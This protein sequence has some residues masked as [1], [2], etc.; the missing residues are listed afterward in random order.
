MVH[1]VKIPVVHVITLLELG[2]A[3]QNTLHTVAHLDR[4]RF[5]PYLLCG[6]GGILDPEARQLN[7]VPVFFIPDLVREIRPHRDL[8]A[9][10]QLRRR[11]RHIRRR[12][13]HHPAIVH[14]HSSKAGILGRWAAR[15]EGVPRVV[16]TFHGFG[17]HPQ[18][19]PWV[20][21]AFQTAE[22]LTG[23]ITD[24]FIVVS[25]QNMKTA[26][27]LGIAG[28]SRM[29]L[30]RSGIAIEAFQDAPEGRWTA[31]RSLGLEADDP[32][33]LMVA[34]L[35][36]Q[37]APVD[38]VAVAHRVSE[39]WPQCRFLLAGDGILRP[40]VEEA[41][42]ALGLKDRFRLLGW[43]RDIPQLLHASDLLVLT[44]RWEGLPRVL[45][46]AM[47]AGLPAVVTRVDGSPEAIADGVNG[48]VREPGDIEGMA[49]AVLT[50]LRDPDL[51]RR[52]GTEGRRRVGEFDIHE[53]VRRQE[54]L[55]QQ[56]ADDGMRYENGR[57]GTR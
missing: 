26:A 20:R 9:L 29:V 16:H 49:Q 14:T 12:H 10:Q 23:R 57:G 13:P 44:S 3:Q 45:P 53:M 54:E 42:R 33:V 5:Q 6:P 35:K 36:P 2:G 4:A 56:L 8:G 18:Q 40:R 19:R 7:D 32:V 25:R 48:F 1:P 38:Y 28:E 37:K 51:R 17:F 52:M 27:R 34:C 30:I 39:V 15:L 21:W 55:Y 50:L 11:I 22:R 47:A 41:A 24:R 43:R 46:Q 31:R